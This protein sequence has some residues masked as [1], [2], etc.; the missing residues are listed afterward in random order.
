M[1]FLTKRTLFLALV[2]LSA[3]SLLAG[4]PSA[5][6]GPRAVFNTATQTGIMFGGGTP[7]D[8]ATSQSYEVAETWEWYESRFIRRYPEHN[9]PARLQ[10]S[11]VYDSKR[12]RVWMFG[13]RTSFGELNDLWYYE[14]GDWH[15]VE[16][17]AAPTARDLA[18]MTYDPIRDRILLYGGTRFS[19]DRKSLVY[20]FDLWEFDG[21]QWTR[22]FDNGP[23]VRKPVMAYDAKR[24]EILMLGHNELFETSM[25][26]YDSTANAF[27]P[28]TAATLPCVADSSLSY[29]PELE[30][31]VL[32]GG[33]CL[34]TD[35]TKISDGF[36]DVFGW[37]G[38]DWAELKTT[39]LVGRGVNQA[40]FYDQKMK[41]L[42]AFGGSFAFTSTPQ[43]TNFVYL[44]AIEDFVV[45]DDQSSPSPR[46]LFGM[47]TDPVNQTI[48]LLGGVADSG[49]ESDFWKFDQ[50]LW[51][52]VQ[53]EGTPNC[54]SPAMAFDTNRARLVVVCPNSA[55]YEWDGAAWKAFPD[56]QTKPG[57]H[58]FSM[59]A[60]DETLRKT[61]FYGGYDEQGGYYDKTWTWDGTTWVEV[62]KKKKAPGRSL[63][64]MWYDP[65]LRKTVLYGGIGRRSFNSRIERYSDMWTFDGTNWTEIKPS[66]KP[67]TRYGA[68]FALN[69]LTN[70]LILHGGIRVDTVDE[71][72]K[73]QKQV[74]AGDTWE[75]DGSNWRQLDTLGTTPGPRENGGMAWDPQKQWMV[76]TGG[77]S[78]YFHSDTWRLN[79]GQWIPFA[80]GVVTSL[81]HD[82]SSRRRAAGRTGR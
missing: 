8:P 11:M 50:G 10:Q 20:L 30:K 45:V 74:Y 34:S 47:V 79:Q 46:S 61:V 13:G 44:P 70:R 2:L 53:V 57:I 75:W 29:S 72:A 76:L 19:D 3:Q 6:Y 15:Q 23:N 81:S 56:L 24:N 82:G 78:G 37:D 25:F 22:L 36:A 32:V 18:A 9:P 35:P 39:T 69:P 27:T 52:R 40:V 12:E 51:A 31:V 1:S 54:G 26:R 49:V 21:T 33:A 80:E 4:H 5:R 77:W 62:G 73:L 63:A 42:V 66:T 38:T 68:Q 16:T 64:A 59:I 43:N 55:T 48:W 7:L 28:V 14:D 65:N 17:P 71:K 67:G 60:Y 41:Q 58:R